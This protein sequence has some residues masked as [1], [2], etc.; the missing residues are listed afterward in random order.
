MSKS[1]TRWIS[2][3]GIGILVIVFVLYRLGY[4]GEK[5]A[6]AGSAP[7]AMPA[8]GGPAPVLPVEAFLVEANLLTDKIEVS[9]SAIPEEE[10]QITSEIAGKV[11]KIEFEEGKQVEKGAVLIRLND[12]EWRAER[13]KLVVQKRLSEKIA[14]RLKALYEKEGVSLQEY[15]V[16]E[17]EVDRYEAEIK[18]L[19]V[20]LEKTVIRAPFSGVLG[21]RQVSEGSY[22]S[23][24]T[25]IV[26]LVRIDPIHIQFSIPEKYTG[27]LKVG[28]Q[29]SFQLAGKE[30]S[31]PAT[32]VARDPK[33]D[34]NTRTLKFEAKA[35]NPGGRVLPGSFTLVQA[36]LRQFD[37]ALM[38]PT[39]AVV[40][41]LGGKKLYV[42]RNGKAESVPVETGIRQDRAIQI[43]S[44]LQ[45]GDTVITSGILQIQPG[46]PVT[47]SGWTSI[48]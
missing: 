11:A 7:P 30:G 40:P 5:G 24:G 26:P 12:D 18:L 34:A 36:Q 38:V 22:L 21:L 6:E 9:G 20:Q 8:G 13:E 39:E 42:F 37:K 48:K 28:G 15:E 27:D 44:G 35:A 33:I 25:P 43:L 17:A 31:F 16:A 19:D 47:I 4:L 10:V 2:L 46:M 45:S 3:I 23:P 29:V 32:I 41:E 14:N 1:L